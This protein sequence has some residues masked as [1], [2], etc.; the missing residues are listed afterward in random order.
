MEAFA[1]NAMAYVNNINYDGLDLD[2]EYPAKTTVDTSPPEDYENFQTLCD[3]LR[4]RINRV[5]PS[6]LL[7]AAVGIGQDKI[8]VKNDAPPSYNIPN[9]MKNLDLVNLMA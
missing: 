4:E 1:E 5:Q 2:W 7:T 6:F 3:I 8:Y 9:L